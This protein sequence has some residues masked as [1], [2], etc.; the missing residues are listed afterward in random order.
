MSSSSSPE[1]F[2]NY[3]SAWIVNSKGEV[4]IPNSPEWKRRRTAKSKS[5]RSKRARP[6]SALPRHDKKE[7]WPQFSETERHCSLCGTGFS[8]C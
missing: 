5:A 2:V 1:G 6:D 4:C 7:H 3:R 8:R